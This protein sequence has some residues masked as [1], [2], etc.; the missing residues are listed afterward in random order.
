MELISI[1]LAFLL[2]CS[3][4]AAEPQNIYNLTGK[5]VEYSTGDALTGVQIEVI[6]TEISVLSDFDGEF[7]IPLKKCSPVSLR[8]SYISY[9]KKIIRNLDLEEDLIIKLKDDRF[10]VAKTR[11]PNNQS[12]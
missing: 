11:T 4:L 10:K 7:E 12:T 8:I 3:S 2:N 1:A 5:I 6:G 9:Q